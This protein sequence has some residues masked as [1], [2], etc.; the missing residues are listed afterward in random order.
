MNV[1]DLVEKEQLQAD[2]PGFS[3]GDTVKGT[4]SLTPSGLSGTLTAVGEPYI[5]IAGIKLAIDGE[6]YFRLGKREVEAP[7]P[8][9]GEAATEIDDTNTAEAA[10]SEAPLEESPPAVI[11]PDIA[12][13]FKG[14]SIDFSE[15][16]DGMMGECPVF[17]S[18]RDGGGEG[19]CRVVLG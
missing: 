6:I 9:A 10:D 18:L 17:R 16:I 4:I 5:Q 3:A 1:M 19:V 12:I 7:Q 13:S 2:L 14:V 11:K 8:E 15:L